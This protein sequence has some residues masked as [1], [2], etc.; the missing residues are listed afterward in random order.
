MKKILI[1]LLLFTNYCFSQNSGITYQ[2]VV[3]NPNGEELPGVDN[4]YAPLTNRNICLQFGIIDNTGTLEYQ[5]QVQVTTDNF[6]MV[7]LLIGTSSQTGGYSLGFNGIEW[8]ASAKFLKVDIDIQGSC[9]NFEELS[10]QP[11]T[12]VPFAYYS[13]ASDIPGP[14]GED[15]FKSLINTTDEPAGSNCVN[16]GF[17]IEVGIDSNNNNIL[18]FDEI[19]NSLTRFVCDVE[20]GV[21]GE[22]GLK[23]LINTTD[24]PAGSNCVNGGFKIEV[25]IDSNNNN[26]LDFDEIDNSLT[27]FVCDVEDG[28]DGEV[29]LKS[30]INTIDEPAGVNCVNGGTR[31]EVGIDTNNN[32]ILDIDE[33]DTSL[34]R[35]ICNGEVAVKTLI[36]SIAEEPGDNCINGGVKIEI[37]EDTNANNILDTDE[38]EESLTRYVCNGTN[39]EDGEDGQDGGGPPGSGLDVGEEL[40]LQRD[41]I[42]P[43]I[44][45]SGDG[46]NILIAETNSSDA[47]TERIYSV[48]N[49]SNNS[50]TKIGQDIIFSS[51]DEV[52]L[53]YS[54]TG[55]RINFDGTKI[56]CH[57]LVG[58]TTS[59][60]SEYNFIDGSWQLQNT[61]SII[62]SSLGPYLGYGD[63]RASD[64]LST[65]I[66]GNKVFQIDSASGTYTESVIPGAVSQGAFNYS[67]SSDG[68]TL[69][70]NTYGNSIPPLARVFKKINNAWV[71]QGQDILP[72]S[73]FNVQGAG[74]GYRGDLSDDG[75][76][77]VAPWNNGNYSV[78]SFF[79]NQWNV[80]ETIE[81]DYS[82][83]PL[84][85]TNGEYLVVV[86]NELLL[87]Y[88]Y[89]KC[90]VFKFGNGSWN[91]HNSSFTELGAPP[92]I[93]S[94]YSAGMGF[95]D[96]GIFIESGTLAY[97]ESRIN[98]RSVL[99]IKKLF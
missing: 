64:D 10:N 16:G 34:T 22:V 57:R 79:D 89:L 33:I 76:K 14:A 5:E 1:L 61:Y 39:G 90:T 43:S 12:Y 86:A 54:L 30:L 8:S 68:N 91:F 27:R 20:D 88:N 28:V 13:P 52:G 93:D 97:L 80:S 99:K 46:N 7:N 73:D 98:G 19:D 49:I 58:S 74:F 84:L 38:V 81:S 59:V 72:P 69:E 15:G 11:F 96:Q 41:L 51:V 24:E 37:G 63:Y 3:Y 50:L 4:P 66:S 35:F 83:L 62:N 42:G 87:T 48:Y 31:I 65:L 29:G 85:N 2:A 71:Q 94:V 70:G 17:K 95:G 78:Y 18:D 47:P 60:I 44:A 21:D 55:G 77:Y 6:G 23:S 25:G 32:N 82:Y 26:I 56:L 92:S 53:G 36:N 40:I 45:L 67:I 9:S 75:M